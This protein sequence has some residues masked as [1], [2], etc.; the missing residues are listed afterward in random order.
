MLHFIQKISRGLSAFMG[1]GTGSALRFGFAPKGYLAL[2]IVIFTLSL[3]G[4]KS[5]STE[6]EAMADI[7]TDGDGVFDEREVLNGTSKNNPCDPKP[8][9]GY[10]GYDADNNIW[11][12][13]DCDTDGITN[14]QEL[15]DS[16]DPFLD[17]QKDIDGDGIPDFQEIAN[18]TDANSL[19]DPVQNEDYTGYNASSSVWADA[20]CDGD[21]IP[22]Y[23]IQ[24]ANFQR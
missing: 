4:C 24:I 2:L 17:E 7:D 6:T 3:A 14:A 11:L 13:A 23:L 12:G 21:G 19:C 1:C 16:T 10:T 18:G 22:S 9:T 5:D 20:N 8:A 15:T